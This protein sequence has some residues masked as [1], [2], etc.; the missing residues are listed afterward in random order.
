MS[1]KALCG[2]EQCFPYFPNKYEEY[3]YLLLLIIVF[4]LSSHSRN[5][6]INIY[7]YILF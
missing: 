3:L 2:V 1:F 4:V 7:V 6:G 5:Q